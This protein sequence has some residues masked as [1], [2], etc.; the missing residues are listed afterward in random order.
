MRITSEQK[1]WEKA[2]KASE[3]EGIDPIKYINVGFKAVFLLPKAI[4]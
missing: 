3:L 4:C 2:S 1:Y